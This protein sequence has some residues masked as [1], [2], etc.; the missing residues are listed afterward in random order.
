[1]TSNPASAAVPARAVRNRNRWLLVAILAVFIGPILVA[2]ALS[3]GG[4][5]PGGNKAYGTLIDP[6]RAIDTAPITLAS[7]DKL[8][9]RNPQWQWTLLALPRTTCAQ[10]CQVALGDVMRM[11][12]TLGRNAERL[13]VVYLGAPLPAAAL[14]ALAPLQIGSDDA[15][16]FATVRA[17][18]DDALA[19]AL[20]D[21][22]GYLMM[23]YAPGYDIAGVRRDLPKVI[24]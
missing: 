7:G 2:L 4:W 12:A 21:P 10:A 1:M 18:G 24:K 5:R 17:D 3:R 16:T 23:R 20:V 11:R 8:V 19:L 15:D 14:S 22:G 13:R 9:W 6:P